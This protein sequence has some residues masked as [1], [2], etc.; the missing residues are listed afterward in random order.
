MESGERVRARHVEL[1]LLVEVGVDD[2]DLDAAARAAPEERDG[3][4]VVLAGRELPPDVSADRVRSWLLLLSCGY[5][6][7]SRDPHLA[8]R[9]RRRALGD[10][11]GQ[12]RERVLLV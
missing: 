4:T 11:E 6:G 9:D 2:L 1:E 5:V 12:L 10:I 8:D 7:R 3:E